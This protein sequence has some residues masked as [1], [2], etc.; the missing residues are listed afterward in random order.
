M[1]LWWLLGRVW[2]IGRRRVGDV[3]VLTVRGEL[4]T[5]ARCDEL[6]RV[7]RGLRDGTRRV[8]LDLAPLRAVDVRALDMLKI[9]LRESRE[10]GAE[11]K[12]AAVPT[13]ICSSLALEG[14]PRVFDIHDTVAAA[15]DAFS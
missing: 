5:P 13:R 6:R 12:L 8:V 4:N 9:S 14:V 2:H 1:D 15:I 3:V 10:A 11:L 7:L